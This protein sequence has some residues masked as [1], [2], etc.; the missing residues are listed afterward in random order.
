MKTNYPIYPCNI[1][2]EED[3]YYCYLQVTS[4]ILTVD[5]FSFRVL[6]S[7]ERVVKTVAVER[8]AAPE[9]ADP[10]ADEAD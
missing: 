5:G 7:D 8:A 9:G 4:R 3:K 10:T 2:T 1:V 6:E